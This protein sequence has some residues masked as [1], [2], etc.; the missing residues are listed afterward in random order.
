MVLNKKHT[1][2]PNL[3]I[4]EKVGKAAAHD[5]V[6]RFKIQDGQLIVAGESSSFRGTLTVEFSK[7]LIMTVGKESN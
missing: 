6:T 7:V 5:E 4:F 2:I 1:V 3:D